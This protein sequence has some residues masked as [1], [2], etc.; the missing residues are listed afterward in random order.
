MRVLCVGDIH[1]SDRPPGWC[2]DDYLEEVFANAAHQER[3]N[4]QDFR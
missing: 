4:R 3:D 1:L 2:T